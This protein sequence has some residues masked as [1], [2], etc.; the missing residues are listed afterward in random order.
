[1]IEF[2]EVSDIEELI[3]KLIKYYLTARKVYTQLEDQSLMES[4]ASK[5]TY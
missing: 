2:F 1:M 4:V 5:P 3:H